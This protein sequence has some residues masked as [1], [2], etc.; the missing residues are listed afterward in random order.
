MFKSYLLALASIATFLDIRL[1]GRAAAQL[2]AQTLAALGGR[3]LSQCHPADSELLFRSSCL[4][5]QLLL[6]N[7]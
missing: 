2:A 1:P 5:F 3:I 4:E 7:D 6:L